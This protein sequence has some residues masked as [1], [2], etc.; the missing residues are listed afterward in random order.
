MKDTGLD[1]EQYSTHSFRHTFAANSL[2]AGMRIEYLS[3]VLG[4]T[5]PATTTIY[6]QLFSED[7]KNEVMKYPFPF[8]DLLKQLI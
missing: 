3:Q 8:E 7:L 5:N 4:H 2:K 6:V 1:L